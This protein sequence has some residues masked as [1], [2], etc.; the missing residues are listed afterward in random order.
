[1]SV[2]FASCVALILLTVSLPQTVQRT[3][4]SAQNAHGIYLYSLNIAVEGPPSA[5]G[6]SLFLQSMNV[7]GTDGITLVESWSTLEPDKGVFEWELASPGPSQFDQWLKAV[8]SAGKKINLAIR[9]G[10]DEPTWL[11]DPV[12]LDGAG[13]TPFHFAASPHQGESRDTCRRV[14]IA[15]PWDP[16]FLLEWGA[17]LNAVSDHL[18]QVGAYDSVKMVR[19][20][21]I[22]RST[23]EFRLPEEVLTTPCRTNS[24][25]KWLA[26]GY[27]PRLLESAWDAIT[28]EF[29]ASFPDKTFNVPIIPIATGNDQNPFPEID[30]DGCV[31]PDFVP[32]DDPHV[33]CIDPAL[34]TEQ[35][36]T[37]LNDVLGDLL[38]IA[39]G[40]FPGHLVIEFENLETNRP[41]SLAVVDAAE[42]F[43][44]MTAFMTNN[45]FA[46]SRSTGGAAC[47]G[48]FLH[49]MD[50][51][52]AGY[53]ALLNIGIYPCQSDAC[54]PDP[55]QSPFIEVIPVDALSFP[56]AILEAH[57]ELHRGP[58]AGGGRP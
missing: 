36:N 6:A 14:D 33:P 11:F 31:F 57:T 27:R 9:A 41:A 47:S 25:D 32:P 3:N 42:E 26:A 45:Y 20:T 22:N 43:Q 39:S 34:T 7:P 15:A 8:M 50:C 19:L 49:P 46:A 17:M 5:A 16:V 21:G 12:G 38:R 52:N 10:A 40:K 13:A 37:R 24:I 4:R 23:D 29:L 2:S 1:M 35:Q 56:D 58:N 28:T 53:V 48:G 44:E 30:D 51:D 54:S 18:R 55:L